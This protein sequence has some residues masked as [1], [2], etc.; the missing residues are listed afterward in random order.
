MRYEAKRDFVDAE[1]DNYN[2]ESIA[3]YALPLETENL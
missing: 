3:Y 1:L 2:S